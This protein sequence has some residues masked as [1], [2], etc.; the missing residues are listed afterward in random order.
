MSYYMNMN[1]INNF[2]VNYLEIKNFSLFLINLLEKI[3]NFYWWVFFF[4][5]DD[6]SLYFVFYFRFGYI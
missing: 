3:K 4:R 1:N 6:K 2:S 5:C